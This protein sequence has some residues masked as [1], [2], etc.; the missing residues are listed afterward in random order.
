MNN[1]VW[2]IFGPKLY[3]FYWST[4]WRIFGYNMS[5]FTL[6]CYPYLHNYKI[7]IVSCTHTSKYFFFDCICNSIFYLFILDFFFLRIFH[8]SGPWSKTVVCEIT[9][10][11]YEITR[12]FWKINCT[13]P[14]ITGCL[15]WIFQRYYTISLATLANE[16][17]T[18]WSLSELY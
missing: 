18:D 11:G 6:F 2:I 9:I 5:H 7:T 14:K 12:E 3:Q 17:R 13:C 15:S 4:V 1:C 10:S 8:E 16:L